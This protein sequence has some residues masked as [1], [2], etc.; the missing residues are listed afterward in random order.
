M[1]KYWIRTTKYG[2]ELPKSVAEALEIDK[3]TGTTFWKD[4]IDK[5]M[6]NNAL[7]LKFNGDDK[8]PIGC[9][10]IKCHMIFEIKMVGL[11]RKACFV[12]GGHLTD[13]PK[14]SVYSSVVTRESV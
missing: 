14:D 3:R 1:I 7:A 10:E 2:I 6:R 5:E 9:K 4:A 13:P 12:A 11:V 8:V